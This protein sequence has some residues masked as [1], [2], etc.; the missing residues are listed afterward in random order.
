MLFYYLKRLKNHNW[1]KRK[2]EK[3]KESMNE[4]PWQKG[5]LAAGLWRKLNKELND[6]AYDVSE[7][8]LAQSSAVLRFLFPRQ[9]FGAELVSSLSPIPTG[10]LVLS[11]LGYNSNT[12]FFVCSMFALLATYCAASYNVYLR[13]VVQDPHLKYAD[14]LRSP[15]NSLCD[16]TLLKEWWFHVL[17]HAVLMIVHMFL[18]SAVMT[19][20]GLT[21]A[22]VTL[23]CGHTA[24]AILAFASKYYVH[25]AID[26]TYSSSTLSSSSP[27]PSSAA[28]NQRRH[29][30]GSDLIDAMNGGN[31]SSSEGSNDLVN[32]TSK[33]RPEDAL[34]LSVALICG[35]IVMLMYCDLHSSTNAVLIT[36][37]SLIYYIRSFCLLPLPKHVQTLPLGVACTLVTPFGIRSIIA[38][39]FASLF[40]LTFPLSVI[41]SVFSV[42]SK[43]FI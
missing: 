25:A 37:A 26:S 17:M 2:K 13:E 39:G 12:P 16:K 3:N 5:S 4:K 22:L 15:L 42:T 38:G 28:L 24:V 31:G 35:G 21:R 29:R 27:S 40:N 1:K 41:A 23:G 7:K 18:M 32:D 34:W 8:G 43:H 9:P 20:C 30:S 33:G 11:A 19:R 36:S 10:I 6:E 14:V